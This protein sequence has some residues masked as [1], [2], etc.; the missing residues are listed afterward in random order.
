MTSPEVVRIMSASFLAGAL[1]LFAFLWWGACCISTPY[2]ASSYKQHK[3]VWTATAAAALLLFI[4]QLLA[5]LLYGLHLLPATTSDSHGD[6]HL[7]MTTQAHGSSPAANPNLR[8]ASA[9]GQLAGNRT[10]SAW[11]P[12]VDANRAA[13]LHIPANSTA[14]ITAIVLEAIGLGSMEGLPVG[15][16][17]LVRGV[18]RAVAS[19]P[20]PSVQ[21]V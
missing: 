14:S 16:I 9:A 21:H 20:T 11:Q 8:A 10:T 1:F 12:D 5:Q 19:G 18:V 2:A 13:I 4:L 3:R 7:A 6:M 17:L 15:Y